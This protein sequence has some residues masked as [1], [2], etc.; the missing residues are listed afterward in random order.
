MKTLTLALAL[1]LSSTSAFAFSPTQAAKTLSD[2]AVLE[3]L[4]GQSIQNF[5]NAPAPRCAGCF[6]LYIKAYGQ[7]QEEIVYHVHGMD[8]A[9]RFSVR[10]AKME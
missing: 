4:E 6:A 2:P 1:L 5:E 10:I 9:G 8:F 7:G 3:A